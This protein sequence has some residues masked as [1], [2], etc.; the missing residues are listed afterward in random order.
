M[1]RF[2]FL[3]LSVSVLISA[4]SFA[5]YFGTQSNKEKT[6]QHMVLSAKEELTPS[7]TSSDTPT[8]I[9]TAT[10]L[11]IIKNPSERALRV[12][13]VSISYMTNEAR[14]SIVNQYSSSGDAIEATRNL[15]FYLDSNPERLALAEA[16]LIKISQNKSTKPSNSKFLNCTSNTNGNY[17]YT[18]CY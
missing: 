4:L 12:A 18:N 15:A 13:A 5:Y 8:P 9:P 11:P 7:V 2:L 10:P 14:Q 6:D 1:K 3:S 17:T 16:E